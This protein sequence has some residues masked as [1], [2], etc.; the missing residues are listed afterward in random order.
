MPADEAVNELQALDAIAAEQDAVLAF[1]ICDESTAFEPVFLRV[2]RANVGEENET[3][4]LAMSDERGLSLGRFVIN[5]EALELALERAE[6]I[7]EG[8]PEDGGEIDV[9]PLEWEQS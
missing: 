5:R 6:A 9:V 2:Y 4:L 8:D 3:A 1:R 7:D